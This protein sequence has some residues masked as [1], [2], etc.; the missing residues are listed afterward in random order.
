[1]AEELYGIVSVLDDEHQNAVWNIWGEIEREFGVSI[2]A[3]HVPH[4]SYHVAKTYGD[5]LHGMLES[6]AGETPPVQTSSGILGIFNAPPPLFFLPLVRT[7][8]LSALHRRLWAQLD[9]IATGVFDRYAPEVWMAT[10]NLA[11]DIE[12][13]LSAE[14]LPYLLKRDLH[15]QITVDNVC[16]LHDTGERQVLEARFDLDRG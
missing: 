6:I 1:M 11:P 4:F 16:L 14:L 13:D 9:P 10:V 12:R 2:S 3:T 15:W 7:D 5:N 8:A